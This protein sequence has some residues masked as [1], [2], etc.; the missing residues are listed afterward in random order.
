MKLRK[1]LAF[2]L[3]AAMVI[4]SAAMT[5]F[6]AII[7]EGDPNEP[8]SVADLSLS[9][10]MYIN[11]SVYVAY[12][13]LNGHKLV[14]DGDLT[15]SKNASLG[16]GELYVKGDF[17]QPSGTL[18]LDNGSLFIDGNYELRVPEKDTE[19]N[20]VS[21]K[22]SSGVLQMDDENDY[23]KVGG[24]MYFSSSY[25]K[26]TSY[27]NLTNGTLEL[28]GNFIQS[29]YGSGFAATEDHKVLFTG[30]KVQTV[31]FQSP[32]GSGFGTLISSDSSNAVV[33]ITKGRILKVQ[34][35]PTIRS[36]VQYGT[37]D[38]TGAELTV[39]NSFTE[40]GDV[41]V[42]GKLTV[43]G[44]YSHLSGTLALGGGTLDIGGDYDLRTPQKNTDGE[45]VSYDSSSGVLQMKTV[46]DYMVV[47][48][49]MYFSSSYST[50]TSYNY[51]K[52]GKLELRGNFTQSGYGSCFNAY[53]THKVLFTGSKTQTIE[54][55]SPD[56][57]GFGL[58]LTSKS[59][60]PDVDIISGRIL[61]AQKGSVL[62]NFVQYG[63]LDLTGRDLTV[64]G[65]FT[66]YGN[67][68]VGGKLTV[69]GKYS[70]LSGTLALAGGT[71]DIGG[72]YD[73]R[74]PRFDS[75][76]NLSHYDASGGVLQMTEESAYMKVG[77]DMYFG[78]SYPTGTSYNY[79]TNGTLELKGNFTQSGYG[80]CF[81][82][83]EEHKVIFTGTKAQ[84]AEFVN[85][86][87]SGF[88]TLIT[89]ED[90][91]KLVDVKGR[92]LKV[93]NGSVLRKFEQ[94]QSLDLSGSDLT[95][96][97]SFIEY[98]NVTIGGKLAVD[99]NYE[100]YSG[101]LRLNGGQL[102]IGGDYSLRVPQYDSEGNFSQ[103]T[104]S[105]GVLQMTE[106]SD[107]MKVG[108]D[109]YF[110]S[111]YPTGSSYNDLTNG[112]LELQGD[113]YQDGYGSSFQANTDHK[114]IFTGTEVQTVEFKNAGSSGFGTLITSDKANPDVDIISGCIARIVGSP[115]L[116]S[117]VQ[118]G[119]LDI[120][121]AQ[122]TVTGDFTENGNV[123][124]GGK[125]SIGGNYEQ[126]SGTLRL[127]GGQ[128][129][130]GG[131]YSLR[132]PQYDSEGNFSHYTSSAGVLQMTE[133]SDY[134]RVGGDMYVSS[135]YGSG[136]SYND[137]TN[138]TLE[139]QGNFTQSGYG[140]SFQANAGHKV[141]FTGTKVQTVEFKNAGSSGFG[142]LITSDKANPDVDITSGCIAKI[143][144]SPTLKNF[145]QYGNID[146]S[147]AKLTL[148]GNMTQRG[149]VTIGGT[150]DV[151]GNYEQYSGTL[152]LNGGQLLIDGDYSLRVPQYDSEGNFSQYTSSAGV[153]QMTEE[154]DY[155]RV[156][157]DMYVS[158]SYGKGTSYNCLTNGT[159]ELQGNFTQSGY[160]SS[161][162]GEENHKVIFTGEK[163]QTVTFTN[164]GSS[165]FG[166]LITSDKAN[167]DV[168]ITSGC[169]G[170]IVGSPTIK[171]FVQYGNIDI[172]G[173]KLTL[174]GNMTQ[175]GNVTIGGTI[176]VGGNYEQYSGTLDLNG[177]QL[178]IDGDYSLRTPQYDTEGNIIS[179]SH[180]SGV[181]QMDQ[182]T[183]YMRVEGDFYASSNYGTGKSYNN[184]SNGLLELR[185]DFTQS[186]SGLSA[187]GDHKT[188]LTGT[189]SQRIQSGQG[190]F[191]WLA[192]PAEKDPANVFVHPIS[193]AELVEFYNMLNLSEISETL[194]CENRSV[195]IAARVAGGKGPYAFFLYAKAPGEETAS[196]VASGA[197]YFWKFSYTP[198]TAGEYMLSV[199]IQDCNG[200]VVGK[201]FNLTCEHIDELVNTSYASAYVADLNET[202]TI[203]A[204]QTGGKAPF[205]HSYYYKRPSDSDWSVL[206]SKNTSKE[207]QTFSSNTVSDYAIKVVTTDYYGNVAEKQF[208][209]SVRDLSVL[210]TGI[211]L[212]RSTANL[213]VGR[214]TTATAT[215]VPDEATDKTVTWTSS[216]TAVATVENG[217][218]TA[219]AP[220]KATITAA[221]VNGLTA[222]VAVTVKDST[223]AVTG[224][225]L[226][227]T[228]TNLVKGHSTTVTATISPSNAT[229]QTVTWTTS[230]AAVAT[231]DNGRI[232]A[233]G[234]GTATVTAATNNGKTATV[235]VKVTVPV[236]SITL[237]RSTANL[238]VGRSTTATATINP[239]DA[240]NKT[241]TWTSSNKSV[242]TVD[243][244]KIT[245]VAPGTATITAK[246]NNGKTATVKVTV[247]ES[248]TTVAVTGITLS[249]TTTNLA[250]GRSTTVTATVAPTNAT[251]KTVTWT[252][253]DPTIATVDN[254][255]ITAV[256]GGTATVTA[257]SNNGKTATVT[258]KV[259]VPVESITLSREKANLLVGRSTTATATINP[260]NA[261]NKTV[262][263]TSSDTSVAT[264]TNGKITAVGAGT[265]TI[266]A[267]TNNGKT[268]TVAVTVKA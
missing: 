108:G 151:G 44:K 50:G 231:V 19:G 268:A 186:N 228:T 199:A 128:F 258:V 98:G 53:A 103:Y 71:L 49:D 157:G 198:T 244:G 138:G 96:T 229:N 247:K 220:G 74:Y 88:G 122:L 256:G 171:N 81:D 219:I 16:G 18:D 79:L 57:S 253:S 102:L 130:V 61:T 40:Y 120:T 265:A 1:P 60:N 12:L 58:M 196:V 131:D 56:G 11:R 205:T 105:D 17:K 235:T 52:N 213:L 264:V 48:G 202:V 13:N 8:L 188:L 55:K 28:Q 116:N 73:L 89:S 180:S 45:I 252:T 63:T 187:Y 87:S 223:V 109:M 233:V 185:G 25:G 93:Q 78:S 156:G 211:T 242:A 33:D 99:G 20:I 80:S 179:Y 263:W 107:Y 145:V 47:G 38:A 222:T 177:G 216:N 203:T 77:G 215:I 32:T 159:L 29:G 119:S 237:S 14:V 136:T 117:F 127:N 206:G 31:E 161:F 6:A 214:S 39:T 68:T 262:K 132:V 169:I 36:F 27:N 155:M 208:T 142:T 167:P 94:Y 251:N 260:T 172:S 158:S 59:A 7:D 139:L 162:V 210:P 192:T 254:G 170:R 225:T 4:P 111:S 135:S 65:N 104:S 245:A 224:I 147:G 10:D 115:T 118:Y 5:S 112:L 92:I 204:E 141:I 143:V 178:L 75:E 66:E 176:E 146:I 133:E 266:T 232:T 76:G 209:I 46:S 24:D 15:L 83:A 226:S 3:T 110:G 197:G 153:L 250:V 267:T 191:A 160:G 72:D 168:D 148:T 140:S 67:V 255:K 26:G 100:Q 114:V 22:Q 165:G 236:E 182:V 106:E 125:L 195:D 85:P 200:A 62:K 218:I 164:P 184:L 174:T 90:A 261:T 227:K 246:S 42:G 241:V 230:N 240:T 201:A 221:T 163:T 126:Y 86:T 249:K 238:L 217:K 173:A 248:T 134:M 21:Y 97:G 54:F 91:N 194:T 175:R 95:V 207:T 137:L 43:G 9:D 239:S 2:M 259:T 150:I 51:L 23:M 69:G 243:N 189:E 190:G 234:G 123:S 82:A 181:L 34:G 37:L 70:Q 152:D 121:D 124:I 149:N 212:S 30:T 41:T 154:S 257:T 183:D 64:T 84:I 129:L 113:F 101:T 144:G 166:S 193:I 35:D